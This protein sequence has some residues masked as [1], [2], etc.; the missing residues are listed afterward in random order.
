MAAPDGPRKHSK[1]NYERLPDDQDTRLLRSNPI[2]D[3]LP[4]DHQ[5]LGESAF[6]ET[7]LSRSVIQKF[8]A[9]R[10]DKQGTA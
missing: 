5:N 10:E 6:A 4:N 1:I 8:Q 2:K 3:R 9:V 7:D